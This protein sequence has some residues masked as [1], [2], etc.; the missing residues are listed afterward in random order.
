MNFKSASIKYENAISRAKNAG[1]DISSTVY[2][3]AFLECEIDMYRE[4]IANLLD[5]KEK[6]ETGLNTMHYVSQLEAV[7]E[8]AVG[9]IIKALSDNGFNNISMNIYKT[10]EE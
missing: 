9:E 2:L 3:V 7:Q 1:V 4:K 8:N 6:M 10:K 5:E